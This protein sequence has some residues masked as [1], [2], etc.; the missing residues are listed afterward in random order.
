MLV[1]VS[2]IILQVCFLLS[3]LINAE[4]IDTKITELPE[5]GYFVGLTNN[6]GTVFKT[7]SSNKGYADCSGT[8]NDFLFIYLFIYA[9]V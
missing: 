3:H 1:T 5:T 7:A 6:Q 4:D 8:M 9:F 2:V